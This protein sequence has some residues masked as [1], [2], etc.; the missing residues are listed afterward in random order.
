MLKDMWDNPLYADDQIPSIT[1]RHISDAIH[2]LSNSAA[3]GYDGLTGEIWKRCNTNAVSQYLR[4]L[5]P[6]MFKTGEVLPVC[7][8]GITFIPKPDKPDDAHANPKVWRPI[9]LLSTIN[10]ILGKLIMDGVKEDIKAQT[11]MAWKG[12][13]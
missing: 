9:T 3:P 6:Y 5:I 1:K 8:I 12:G 11:S 10:K 7:K 13:I 2:S 4:N